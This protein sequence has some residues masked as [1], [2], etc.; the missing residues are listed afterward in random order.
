MKCPKCSGPLLCKSPRYDIHETG[1]I[2]LIRKEI[3]LGKKLESV[4]GEDAN[5][6]YFCED[7]GLSGS[8][9]TIT[10]SGRILIESGGTAVE[11]IG[12]SPPLPPLPP[13]PSG[14]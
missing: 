2:H 11:S 1:R 7:C 8:G 14:S 3:E 12:V 10:L 13:I 9:S 6:I 5:I 4:P